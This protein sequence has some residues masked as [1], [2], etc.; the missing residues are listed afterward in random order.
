MKTIICLALCALVA[1]TYAAPARSRTNQAEA[2]FLGA[3]LSFI[4]QVIR[5]ITGGVEV[6]DDDVDL[7]NIEAFLSQSLQNSAQMEGD[8]LKKIS[9][10][11]LKVAKAIR[12]LGGGV[13]GALNYVPKV[14]DALGGG[15]KVQ[16]VNNEDLLGQSLQDRAEIEGL[17]G[18]V[19]RRIGKLA[20]KVA[21]TV[22]SQIPQVISVLG[23]GGGGGEP[24]NGGNDV[25][26][27]PPPNNKPS[28]IDS[29][30]EALLSSMQSASIKAQA[31]ALLPIIFP[32]K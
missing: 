14:I 31:N 28:D 25:N 12:V 3:L 15:A 24:G 4:P 29:D 22:L 20:V 17:A 1:T 11:A 5:K 27:N 10:G 26:T 13:E 19:L 30:L 2:Q 18:S 23:G 8:V 16:D 7:A 6:Q 21:P 32:K 9:R